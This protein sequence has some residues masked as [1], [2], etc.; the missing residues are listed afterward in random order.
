MQ[1]VCEN[2]LDR[3]VPLIKLF[4]Q[5]LNGETLVRIKRFPN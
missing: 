1:V 3:S 2:S 5:F 4:F